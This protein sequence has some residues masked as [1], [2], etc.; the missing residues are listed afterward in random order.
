LK[1]APMKLL[2]VFA[3]ILVALAP[4]LPLSKASGQAWN[5]AANE[6]ERQFMR[7]DSTLPPLT[8]QGYR[9]AVTCMDVNSIASEIADDAGDR[10]SEHQFD[11]GAE[12]S[13]IFA[14]RIGPQLGL[15]EETIYDDFSKKIKDSP[16][17]RKMIHDKKYLQD[18]ILM[19]KRVGLV[20]NNPSWQNPMPS[21]QTRQA[22]L[23]RLKAQ[24]AI[25]DKFVDWSSGWMVDRYRAG[26]AHI[27]N[28]SCGARGCEAL[29]QF[30]FLRMGAVHTIEF[31]AQFNPTGQNQYYL[32]RLCY[33]DQTTGMQDCVN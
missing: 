14:H 21:S 12:K 1:G 9:M 6:A 26:S 10:R 16:E 19:C 27:E 5:D 2:S 8:L 15:T 11:L 30:T 24:T 29:G 33:N 4:F 32:V 25:N 20:Y 7:W 3:W 18:S 17:L 23:D 13:W 22:G 28:M 31:S